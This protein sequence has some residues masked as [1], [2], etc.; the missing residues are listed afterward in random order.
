MSLKQSD[1]LIPEVTVCFRHR[2][3]VT[4]VTLLTSRTAAGFSGCLFKPCCFST[5]DSDMTLILSLLIGTY[6]IYENTVVSF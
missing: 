6:L 2:D 5:I 1:Q 4:I 3:L